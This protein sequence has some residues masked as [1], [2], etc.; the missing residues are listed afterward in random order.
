MLLSNKKSLQ[1]ALANYN[2][3]KGFF[4]PCPLRLA[5]LVPFGQKNLYPNPILSFKL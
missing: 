4:L 1:F 5:G 2:D 3:Y